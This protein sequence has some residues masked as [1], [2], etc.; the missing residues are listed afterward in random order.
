MEIQ[1]NAQNVGP[2]VVTV[3]KDTSLKT[4]GTVQDVFR[5]ANVNVILM[6]KYTTRILKFPFRTARS[7]SVLMEN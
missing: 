6:G 5:K 1:K 7:A 3:L 2:V 4:T